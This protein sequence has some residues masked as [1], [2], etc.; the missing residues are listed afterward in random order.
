MPARA[1]RAGRARGHARLAPLER[2]VWD[3]GTVVSYMA[4]PFPRERKPI[5]PSGMHREGRVGTVDLDSL[6][7]TQDRVTQHGVDKYMSD[8]GNDLPLVYRSS[9]GKDYVADGHHRLAAA[10]L[11]GKRRVKANIVDIGDLDK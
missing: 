11:S 1:S 6:I 9:S 3:D 2:E 10:Y 5:V 8:P 4:S 7:G